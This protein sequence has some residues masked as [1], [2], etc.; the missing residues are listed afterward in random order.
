[1]LTCIA[2]TLLRL[3]HY[4]RWLAILAQRKLTFW[5]WKS[6]PLK[7]KSSSK[8]PFWGSKCWVETCPT[9]DFETTRS[10]TWDP[11]VGV[12]I[13][14]WRS[15]NKKLQHPDIL[16]NPQT[17][18]SSL[19]NITNPPKNSGY[20]FSWIS[21]CFFSWIPLFCRPVFSCACPRWSHFGSFRCDLSSR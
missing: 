10:I 16:N 3:T 9:M 20:I 15:S 17:F 12:E 19:W 4:L 14:E 7:R 2:Y 6:H 5:T 18:T 11:S 21:R 8:P 13:W 1:M